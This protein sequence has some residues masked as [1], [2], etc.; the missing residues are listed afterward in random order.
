[1]SENLE[2]LK[3]I[4]VQ[5]IHEATHIPRVHVESILNE[6]FE[7]MNNVQ[8]LGFI[9]VLEREYPFDFSELKTKVIEHF[10]STRRLVKKGNSANLLIAS[11]KKRNFTLVYVVLGLAI[12]VAFAIFNMQSKESEITRVDNSAIVSA[13][14]NISVVS[15]DKNLSNI[16]SNNTTQNGQVAQEPTLSQQESIQNPIEPAMQKDASQNQVEPVEEVINHETA[17]VVEVAAAQAITDT[18]VSPSVAKE[19]N[20]TE[21]SVQTVPKESAKESSLKII[22]KSKVWMGYIDLSNRRQNQK[23]F[24]GEFTLDSSKNWLISLGH[25]LIDIEIN[26]VI[27]N[28]KKAQNVRFSYIDS[29]LKEIDIEEFKSLNRGNAW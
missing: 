18:V 13:Q 20:E 10:E 17:K 24:S 9:S 21:A 7:D 11:K 15:D 22:S 29:K 16:D 19:V 28:S 2:K 23:T 1:M 4:G 6:N 26:G 25:G 8:L 14:N 27:L 5:K 3:N 12:F